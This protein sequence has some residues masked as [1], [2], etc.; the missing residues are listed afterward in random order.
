MN[1]KCCFLV[2]LAFI[3]QG[4][5]SY[6]TSDNSSNNIN[7]SSNV[8]NSSSLDESSSQNNDNS[9]ISESSSSGETISSIEDSSSG[10]MISSEESTSSIEDS[11]SEESS[12]SIE[13]SSSEESSSS[14]NDSSSP[15]KEDDY[16]KY[17]NKV[18]RSKITYSTPLVNDETHKVRRLEV[19]QIND[20]HGAYIDGDDTGISRVKTCINENT[21]DVYAQVKIAN[22]DM[23]QGSAFSNMLIGEPAVA[24]LNEMNFD[25][26]VIGN[27]EFDWG[28]EKLKDYKDND[29]SNGELNCPFLGANIVDKNNERPSFIEPYTIVNKG[30]M[31]VGIIGVIGDGLEN[32]ISKVSLGDYHFTST[33]EA[34]KKYSEE[35]LSK[36]VDTIIVAS[37]AHDEGFNEKY[38]TNLKVDCIINAHDH[39]DVNYS[40]KR[41]DGKY[42]PVI[43]SRTKNIT[44]G[45]V[46]LNYD[47]N[48][49]Y[50]NSSISHFY[51]SDYDED[52]ALKNL[53]NIYYEVVS[54]YQD[55]VIGYK[56]NGFS[57]EEIAI[58]TCTYIANKYEAD[59]VFVN[60]GGVRSNIESPLITNGHVYSVFPFDNELYTTYI[61]GKEL[62]SMISYKNMKNYYYNNSNIGLGTTYDF[63]NIDVNKL[64]KVMTVDYVATKA[65]MEIYFNEGHSFIKTGLYVR[66]EAI[67]CIK[68]NYEYTN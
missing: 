51:P 1:K 43:E 55:E 34:V 16:N 14:S 45:K 22:G 31:K 32:S 30:D 35:L 53:M 40:I 54:D 50:L 49:N 10:E 7:E 39:Q 52:E 60:T 28:I 57:K 25:C 15:S 47:E 23:M 38:T 24:S 33:S 62:K 58:A 66:D 2:A 9:S 67:E 17:K 37:H 3:F 65:Y 46:V 19:F 36:N 4:C 59:L 41:E 68:T 11:S 13:D 64:Y 44:M 27:H 42:V 61:T 29:L 26:F 20:T 5:N 18:D 6:I 63:N 8:N 48:K 12:S 21:D 56:A